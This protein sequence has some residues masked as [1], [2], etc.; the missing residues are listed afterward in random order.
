LNQNLMLR[1][2]QALVVLG[3][4]VLVVAMVL[5]GKWQLDVY[6]QQGRAASERRA[7]AAPVALTAV[8]PAGGT[9][10]D[11]FGR[12]VGFSGSYE[13]TLQLLVPVIGSPGQLRVLTALRQD[14]G[15][16]V[17]VVRGLAA[18]PTAPPPPTGRVDQTGVLLPSEDNGGDP[19][20]TPGQLTA[21]SLPILAQ[22]WPGP[23][24]GGIVTLAATDATAQSLAP[25]P[26]QLP[27]AGGGLRN[28]AYA[29]QWWLFAAFVLVMAFR[30]VRDLERSA[31]SDA[32][33]AVAL[34]A[35]ALDEDPDAAGTAD[36]SARPNA[37]E[38]SPTPT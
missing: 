4:L 23:L 34:D 31:D 14:D 10:R 16:L 13:P 20:S 11:G 1:L 24:V 22:Q 28:G 8:A 6:H 35:V 27:D 37:P 18:G 17:P 21:I 2:R 12:Q 19:P 29:F 15:S 38:T 9:V 3:A 26:L 32:L 7:T 5:L 25:A 30:I 36:D 33:N